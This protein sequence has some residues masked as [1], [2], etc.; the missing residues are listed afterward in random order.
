MFE[1]FSRKILSDQDRKQLIES[2]TLLE[3][4]EY[5]RNIDIKA[6]GLALMIEKLVCE[7]EEL[8]NKI[9]K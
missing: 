3:I 5:T 1:W 8:K 2:K 9:E 6:G 4:M 7:I